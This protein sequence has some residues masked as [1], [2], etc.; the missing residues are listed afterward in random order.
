[1]ESNYNLYKLYRG[2]DL[3][4]LKEG[5]DG[6]FF[7]FYESKFEE[8]WQKND[9]SDWYDRFDTYGL[10]DRF[11]EIVKDLPDTDASIEDKKTAIFR[12]WLDY[13]FKDKLSPSDRIK[14]NKIKKR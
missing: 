9:S 3:C 7:W 8:A 12:L 1:M 6:A 2:E 10:G 5:S 11:L 13:L 14:Y 4:P